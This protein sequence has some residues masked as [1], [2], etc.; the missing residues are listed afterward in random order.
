MQIDEIVNRVFSRSFMG[1][2]MREVDVF[3]DDVIDQLERYESERKEMLIAMEY[4]LDK[5]ERGGAL[6][7]IKPTLPEGEEAP[8]RKRSRNV[9]TVS[10]EPSAKEKR[11]KTAVPAQ[12]AEVAVAVEL[13]LM[14][15]APAESMADLLPELLT[16]LTAEAETPPQPEGQPAPEQSADEA[17]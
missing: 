16:A 14:T 11:K 7:E 10:P 4:L 2:D 3:L 5:L 9:R 1:Y 8:K 17:L 6:P 12:E 13:E 15:D